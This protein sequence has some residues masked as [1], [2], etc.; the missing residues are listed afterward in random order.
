MAKGTDSSRLS[1]IRLLGLNDIYIF[2]RNFSS[3]VSKY[4]STQVHTMLNPTLSFDAYLPTRGLN[5]YNWCMDIEVSPPADYITSITLCADLLKE[6]CD[7][8]YFLDIHTAQILTQIL[9]VLVH[10]PPEDSTE[11]SYVHYYLSPLMS[12]VFSTDPLLKMKWAN[13]KLMNDQ[14]QYKPDFLVYNIFGSRRC[15][16]IIA[17]FKPTEKNSYVESDL[18]K[19]AKQMKVTLNEMIMN[20]VS[21][22]EVCGVYCEG[23]NV[24]TYIMDLP[25]PKL[26]RL[27]NAS[28]IKLFKR[29][30]QISLL[31]NVITHLLC[32]KNV[33]LKTAT[34][35]ETAS[36]YSYN[37]LKRPAPNPP[38]EW[39]SSVKAVLS[40][41]P[42]K[43]K[44]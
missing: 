2:D 17:E 39:L 29:L 8:K 5:C 1:D 18:V 32:L 44:K 15:V 21:K 7:N 26:Y 3:S 25:S 4:F 6:A 27:V 10:G 30:D 22:P 41:L 35:V 19:L 37:N 43:Q 36:L 13:G 20:G 23:E 40:L 11:D 12:S 33:A 14:S 9:P 31:P 34:K 24:H 38:E 16:I 28:R 42:K